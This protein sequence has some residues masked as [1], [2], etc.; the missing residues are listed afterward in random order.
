MSNRTIITLFL[1][2]A[3]ILAEGCG[4]SDYAGYIKLRYESCNASNGQYEVG[5]DGRDICSCFFNNGIPLECPEGLVC[6]MVH[7]RCVTC[8]EGKAFCLDGTIH[9]CLNGE[10][11]T[12]ACESK[13]CLNSNQCDPIE[14]DPICCKDASDVPICSDAAEN[15]I[16]GVIGNTY[17]LD[18][19]ANGCENGACLPCSGAETRC[20]ES[21]TGEGTAANLI[22]CRN[23]YKR[24]SRV[25]QRG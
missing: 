24:V 6:D 15:G 18:E 12:Q 11:Q 10:W 20:E 23:G 5:K 14:L 7:Q 19:C 25:S 3:A 13:A 22:T 16:L 8:E 17:V 2:A 1:F 21:T 9:I 4:S